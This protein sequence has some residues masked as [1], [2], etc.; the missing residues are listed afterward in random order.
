MIGSG[1][2]LGCWE[3]KKACTCRDRGAKDVAAGAPN[4]AVLYYTRA[5]GCSNDSWAR[6]GRYLHSDEEKQLHHE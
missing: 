3:V 4:P 6:W 5:E 2:P 1:G